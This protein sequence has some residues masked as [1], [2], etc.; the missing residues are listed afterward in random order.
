MTYWWS[1]FVTFLRVQLKI[2]LRICFG[3]SFIT[4][5]YMAVLV[6]VFYIYGNY[7]VKSV[8]TKHGS[9]GLFAG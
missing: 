2:Y 9:A 3:L 7:K 8:F 1:S 5:T 4:L 6:D